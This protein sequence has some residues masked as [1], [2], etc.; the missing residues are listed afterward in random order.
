MLE[1]L[2]MKKIDKIFEKYKKNKEIYNVILPFMLAVL[3]LWQII[4]T[5]IFPLR[6][7]VIILLLLIGLIIY[8]FFRIN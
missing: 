7:N 6:I 3:L 5:L 8:F 2:F 4:F 1:E